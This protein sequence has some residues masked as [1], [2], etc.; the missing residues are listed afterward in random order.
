MRSFV[1]IL[2]V[3]F[4]LGCGSDSS[5]KSGEVTLTQEES[6]Q[7]FLK[8]FLRD[9]IYQMEHITFPLSGQPDRS[10][11]GDTLPNGDFVWTKENWDIHKEIDPSKSGFVV[12]YTWLT[13]NLVE[14]TL[15]NEQVGLGMMRR[16]SRINE[17]EWELIYYVG[18]RSVK[19]Q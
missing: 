4:A 14:E 12:K 10:H 8:K 6:F 18:M 11:A 1:F 9:S 7:S 19:Q 2:L 3:V 17:D 16:F 15:L 13:D 5:K